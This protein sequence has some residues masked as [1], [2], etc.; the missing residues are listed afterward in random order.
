MFKKLLFFN[1]YTKEFFFLLLLLECRFHHIRNDSA[2][3][4]LNNNPLE[5]K[6]YTNSIRFP[7]N[8][9]LYYNKITG[10]EKMLLLLCQQPANVYYNGMLTMSK[11]K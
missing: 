6:K 11:R 1:G 5:T 4:K 3:V 10:D 8:I 9:I 7:N 2:I